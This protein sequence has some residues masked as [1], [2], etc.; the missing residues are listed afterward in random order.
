MYSCIGPTRGVCDNSGSGQALQH[1][2]ELALHGALLPLELP[3]GKVVARVLE[4]G[5]GGD[6]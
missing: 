5:V 1:G 3:A 6:A 4:Y 2:F